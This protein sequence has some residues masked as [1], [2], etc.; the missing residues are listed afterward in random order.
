MSP[1][2]PIV[3]C[4]W[5][6]GANADRINS[7][8]GGIL[9]HRDGASGRRLE[10]ALSASRKSGGILNIGSPALASILG[11]GNHDVR[12]GP[13]IRIRLAWE[14]ASRINPSPDDVYVA[15]VRHGL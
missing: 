6:K 5:S 4:A 10:R 1:S 7:I 12:A 3:T 15:A 8:I 9:N 14:L 11:N 2:G 13:C